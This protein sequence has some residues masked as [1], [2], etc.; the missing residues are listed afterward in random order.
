MADEC[1]S[2]FVPASSELHG[3]CLL[4]LFKLITRENDYINHSYCNSCRNAESV[5]VCIF[6]ALV[7]PSSVCYSTTATTTTMTTADERQFR[8]RLLSS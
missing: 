8:S 2:V 7:P 4:A 1:I 6:A 5:G 3:H